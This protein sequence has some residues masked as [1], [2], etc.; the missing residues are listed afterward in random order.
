MIYSI[1][2]SNTKNYGTVECNVNIPWGCEEVKYRID[3]ISTY[4]NFT[5]TDESD[6]I[7]FEIDGINEVTVKMKKFYYHSDVL[8]H[9]IEMLKEELVES[10]I[11]IRNE[12]LYIEM[13]KE[14]CVKSASHRVCVL[15]GLYNTSFDDMLSVKGDKYTYVSES[16]PFT[17]YGNVMYLVSDQGQ[18]IGTESNINRCVSYR[19]NTFVKQGL[20]IIINKKQDKIRINSA[21]M[22]HIRFQLVDFQFQPVLLNSPL[23]V[24]LKIKP[25]KHRRQTSN[26]YDIYP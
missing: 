2:S 25:F 20:P 11:E 5:L 6:Y 24:Q 3:S 7:T 13:D 1:Q 12:K 26:K 9:I 18:N 17:C 10:V 22:S 15:M 14:F 8:D 4:A 16:T 19:I 21:A 23:F